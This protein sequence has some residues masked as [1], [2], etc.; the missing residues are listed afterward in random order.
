MGFPN[1]TWAGITTVGIPDAFVILVSF[2]S[3]ESWIYVFNTD[4]NGQQV[5]YCSLSCIFTIMHKIG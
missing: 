4:R 3:S 5:Y 1:A 2:N